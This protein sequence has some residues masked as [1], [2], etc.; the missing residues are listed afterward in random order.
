[1]QKLNSDFVQ[2]VFFQ[3]TVTEKY[4]RI[5]NFRFVEMIENPGVTFWRKGYNELLVI[6][7]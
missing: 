7:G 3:Q 1:M 6:S 5:S 2:V 4:G